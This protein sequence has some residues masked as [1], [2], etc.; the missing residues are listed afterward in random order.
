MILSA[1]EDA[2][3]ASSAPDATE[4]GILPIIENGDMIDINADGMQQVLTGRF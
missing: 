3:C 2:G 4:E 1:D